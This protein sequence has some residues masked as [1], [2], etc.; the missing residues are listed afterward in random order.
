MSM[1][2]MSLAAMLKHIG[3]KC[4]G[5]QPVACRVKM[6]QTLANELSLHWWRCSCG[7]LPA[8][9]RAHQGLR[10][11]QG[12]GA[13]DAPEGVTSAAAAVVG[14]RSPAVEVE[15]VRLKRAELSRGVR[16]R[17]TPGRRL[18]FPEGKDLVAH[19]AARMTTLL[20]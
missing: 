12:A 1:V 16:A 2:N 20:E 6:G 15:E 13:R 3:R 9:G 19:N 5:A 10:L 8:T 14:G 11:V 7:W 17:G 18:R 4:D